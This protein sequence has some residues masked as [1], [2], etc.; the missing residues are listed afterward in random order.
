MRFILLR[1]LLLLALSLGLASSA[2]AQFVGP[3]TSD[4]LTTVQLILDNPQDD[5]TVILRGV[6]LEKVGHEK[7]AF[8]DETGQIRVEIDNEVF[9]Q[10]RITP[11]MTVE[12]Y[13]EVEKDFLRNPDIDVERLTVV[14]TASGS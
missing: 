11:D 12:I 2:T 13:G 8:S 10:Q 6:L 1:T 14:D 5:Q 3:G 9:P 4:A 7:Y